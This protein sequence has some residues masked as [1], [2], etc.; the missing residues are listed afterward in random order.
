M[1]LTTERTV[2]ELV[3]ELYLNIFGQKLGNICENALKEILF[4]DKQF[5]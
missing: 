1:T 3:A 2:K 5:N 4:I